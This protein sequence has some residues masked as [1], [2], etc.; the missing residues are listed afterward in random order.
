[1]SRSTMESAGSLI[2][3]H[4]SVPYGLGTV[5]EEDVYEIL[6]NGTLAGIRS[7]AKDVLAFLFHENSPTSILKAV[8]ECGGSLE[9][10]QELYEEIRGMSF[11]PAPEWEKMTR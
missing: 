8:G 11:P 7:P 4:L 1:M 6:K 3:F 5:S 2:A 10:V 9:N